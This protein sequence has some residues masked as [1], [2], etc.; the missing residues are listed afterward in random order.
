MRRLCVTC[1]LVV[2]DGN[3]WLRIETAEIRGG[4]SLAGLVIR[5]S[6]VGPVVFGPIWLSCLVFPAGLLLYFLG[7]THFH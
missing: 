4:C 2:E 6:Q 3:T 7:L 5:V 1:P